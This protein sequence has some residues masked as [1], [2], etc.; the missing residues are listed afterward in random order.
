MSLMASQIVSWWIQ[1]KHK[2]SN[3]FRTKHYFFFE[4]KKLYVK[5]KDYKMAKNSFL[6]K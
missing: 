3:I 6:V 1:Q 4:Y 5:L 2:K